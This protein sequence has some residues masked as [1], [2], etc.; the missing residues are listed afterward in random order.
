[1]LCRRLRREHN[2]SVRQPKQAAQKV[3]KAAPKA[4]GGTKRVSAPIKPKA[5]TAGGTG[6]FGMQRPSTGEHSPCLPGFL[7]Q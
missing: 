2:G 5:P 1:M 3:Q 6:L 7:L 4:L